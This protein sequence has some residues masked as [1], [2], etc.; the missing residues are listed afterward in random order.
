MTLTARQNSKLFKDSDM[1][2]KYN[3]L[4]DNAELARNTVELSALRTQLGS[5]RSELKVTGNAGLTMTDALKNGLYKVFQLFGSHGIIVQF[6]AQ[7]RKA[8]TEAK[9]LDKSMTD[10]SRVNSEITR[11][12]FP[13]YLDKVISKTKQLAVATKDYIDAVTTFSRAGYNLVDSETLAQAA[14]QLEKVG[15][16]SAV[17]ASKALLAGLQGYAEIDGYGMDQLTEKAQALNDKIDLIGNTA[18]I[19][20]AELSRGIQAVGSVMNDANTSVD[21]FLALLGAGNRAVQDSDKVAL[22]IRTSALRIR[23]CTAELEEMGEETDSV[24]ESTSKLAEKIEGLTNINGTGGVKIFEEDEETFRSIFDIYNDIAK[25]YDKMSDKD[26]SA[27]LDLIAGKNR[28]NQISAILQNMSEANE[29]LERSLSAAGTASEEYQIYLNSAEAATERFG[30]AMTEAYSS[31]ISGD[32]V[33]GLANTG[34]AVLDFANSWNILEGTVRGFLALGILK[35]VTTLTVAFKNSA[36]QISNYGAAL[37]AVNQVGV[38]AQGTEKYAKAMNT[39]KSSCVNLTDAQLKQVLA[40]RNLSDSQL[41]EI[42]QLDTLEKE[43]TQARLAQLGLIQ[44]TETQ[45]VVQGAATASTFSFS[46]AIK[47]LGASIKATFMSNPVGII[48]MGISTAIGVATS[49][50]SK[51]NQQL[52]ETRRA[53]IESATT[54][55]EN[56]DKLKDL[57]NEYT[58]LASIQDRT[59]SEEESFKTAIEN[60]IVALGDKAEVLKDL[61]AGTDEY[62][63]ALARATKEELQSQAVTATI[64]RKSAEEDLQ[65]DIWSKW[66]GSQVTIDSNSKGQSL[67]DEAQ[68][69]VDI[70]SESL[71]EFETV[72]R[73]WKNISWDISSDDPTQALEYYNSLV[74]AREKLVLASE[75]DESLLDTEIYEDL[76][77]AINSMSESLD[78]YIEKLYEE[79]KLNYM[80]QN[81]IPQT[82]ESYREMESALVSVAGSS[83][84][85]QD[86]FKE[87]L[88]ADFSGLATDIGNVADAVND[89][90]AQTQSIAPTISSSIQQIATQLEPQFAKLGDAYKE[91]FQFDDNGQEIFSLD[92]IDNSMLEELRQAFAEIKEEVGVTF[93]A[94]KL[95]SF[96]DT[97]TNGDSTAEQVQQAFNDLA[98]VYLYS[99]DTLD[100]LNSETA[101]AIEKQLEELGVQNAAEI[102]ADELTA[103]TEELIVAKEY[104]AQTGQELASA[105]DDEVNAFILEQIEAGN[106]GE[107]LALLQLKKMLVNGTLLDTTADINNVL[108]LAQAAGITSDALTRLASLKAAFDNA[109]ASGNYGAMNAISAEMEKVKNQVETDIANFKPVEIQFDSSSAEKSAKKA[110]KKAGDAYLEAFQKEYDHLKDLLD[111]GEISEAQYL[112]RLRALYNKYFK[113]RKEYLDEYKKYES[114]YLSGMLDLHNKALSGISTLL[115]NKISAANDAKDAAISALEEEKEAAAEAYQAQIDAIEE[116]KDAIDDLIKEKDKK[117]DALNEEADAI[118]KAAD[119]RKKNIDLQKEEADLERMLNQRTTAVYKEGKGFV[120][121]A[122][123]TGIRD[124]REKVKEA[125]EELKIDRLQREADLIQKEID[126]L[127][128]KKDALTEEQEAIQKMLDESNKY[129]D[130]LIKQQEKMWDSMIKGMEQQKSKW[131]ELA[132]IQQIAE[133][134]SAVQQVFGE[135]GYSVEDVLNGSESAFEDFKSK[136][137]SLIHDVNNNSDFTDGL[138]YATGVAKENLGSFLDKTKETGEGIDELAAKGTELNT[139]TDGMNELATSASD[140]NTNLSETATNVGNVATNVDTLKTNLTDVNT[141]VTD[142]QTTFSNLL[143]TIND[144]IEAINQKTTAIQDEQNAVGI[145]TSSEMADFL[146]LKEK[147]LE[148]KETLDTISETVDTLDTTPIDNL[149][150]SFQSLYE[151][152]LLISTT[153]GADIEGQGEGVTNSITSAIQALNEI[154]FEEGIIAQFD[155]LKTAIDSV[156]SAISGGGESSDSEQ[157]S[158]SGSGNNGK[159]RGSNS[160]GGGNSLTGAITSIGDTAKEVIGEP[161]AEG[162]GT[163]IGEFGAMETAVNDVTTAI[164]GGESESGNGQKKGEENSD[165]LIGS[166]TNLG[167]TTEEILGES[168]GNGIIGRF[169][170]FKDVIAEANEQ[171][172]GIS[173]GLAAIDGQTVECTIKINI[174][175]DGFPSYAAGTALGVMNLESAE[176][177]AKYEGNAHVTGTA[178]VTGNWGVRKPGKSLVGEVG[179]E[180]WV[181]SADGTFETV[182][183]NGP[184]WIKTE[185]G[186]LIFNHLQTKELLDK[187]NIVKTGKAYASGTIQYSDGTVIQPDGSVLRPLQPGDKMWD[188][189]QKFDAYF[190]SIDGNL[191]KLVPNSFYEQNREWNKLAD[192][193]T[194]ANSVVNNRNVQ[195]P[196]T[197]QIGD[198]NLTGVQDVNGLAQAIKT[199]LPGQM[200]QEYFKN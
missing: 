76:N 71:K 20:Q 176:Y 122:D 116:E 50:I 16:M 52:E 191:E 199:R 103:K 15:D 12:G 111:R 175:S 27:L 155:N 136:Y 197:I 3:S 149:T 43:Q 99:T 42:L 96:F 113:D 135:L 34:A 187:G 100:Q 150:E 133:A 121:E 21:E 40:N 174:D 143:Q 47:G 198:I 45:T 196:V 119:T 157:G 141:F 172:T 154:S 67:S 73:T 11:S 124:A 48:I 180:I 44:T 66:S 22:A 93:D 59:T 31:I 163:V 90:V 101:N 75:D 160:E 24:A 169:G 25:V 38:Y 83:D 82:A 91:I 88:M 110:G 129:Y 153:L 137:I 23:G 139:V 62:A 98:T 95:D 49:A 29:L 167:E 8:W 194:Y 69:A 56:A 134:Y 80:A 68:K 112:N 97:L 168:D 193:I 6:T 72:N 123:T 128:E 165:N 117:I 60:I 84:D 184:E 126:L 200:M 148:V 189:Y 104:L 53:N 64:G 115:G 152:I 1:T 186:D 138:T 14:V 147:I 132:D 173:D 162:D 185:K 86:R 158:N 85:L 61:T 37:E 41:I 87:L 70:V 65:G 5:F 166:I 32:T 26:A 10:L 17:D 171:V 151:K 33:K 9:E 46:A 178:N 102:V 108:A 58:R 105:T 195:Q 188:M 51:Y 13:D 39:L 140:A 30:V 4:L 118:Q 179:Q 170:E 63:D 2:I 35:G 125:K 109:Q 144:I 192:Q 78:T 19:T 54:A 77:T 131:E 159:S 177:N 181:H 81:G 57:Y 161:D 130:N 120:F 190:K 182:G 28:S 142:E 106:C 18:S 74:E 92:S 107:A 36:L 7:L 156:S 127:E 89:V 94:S 114:E 164:G 79:E 183:D 146:L 55:S 145:A